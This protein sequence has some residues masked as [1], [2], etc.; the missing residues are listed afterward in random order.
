MSKYEVIGHHVSLKHWTR[1][2]QAT[3]PCRFRTNDKSLAYIVVI[4]ISSSYM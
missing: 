4:I 3:Q 1:R 2:L